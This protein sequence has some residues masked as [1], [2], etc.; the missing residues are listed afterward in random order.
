[1]FVLLLYVT[2]IERDEPN[3]DACKRARNELTRARLLPTMR[4]KPRVNA[5]IVWESCAG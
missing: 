3:N 1:M 2:S 4:E 5:S